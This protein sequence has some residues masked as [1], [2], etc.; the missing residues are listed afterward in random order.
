MVF[1]QVKKN[2]VPSH[3]FMMSGWSRCYRTPEPDLSRGM[4][5]MLSAYAT[6]WARRHRRPSHVFQGR[7][8]AHLI[9]DEYLTRRVERELV[10]SAA[11]RADPR[12][13]DDRLQ[14]GPK[15]KNNG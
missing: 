15:T 8:R 14:P 2:Q 6:R 13:I 9:E 10:R 7:F 11:L 5:R 4:H 12:A 1:M 3:I